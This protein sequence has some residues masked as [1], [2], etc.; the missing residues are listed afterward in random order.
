[1]KHED[2]IKDLET[3]KEFFEEQSDAYP[4][5]LEYAIE[6]L[7]K[8]PPAQPTQN[9]DSNAL[10]A[11]DCI[12]R[13]AAIEA[14]G[15]IHSLDYNAQAIKARIE[16]LPSAQP[17]IVRCKDCRRWCICHHAD[18]WFCADGERRTNE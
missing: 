3:L 9:N 1:M 17:E 15:E 12:Y 16:Q 7:K 10:K 6:A 13:Q 5:S 18:D 2:A 4:L 11:L 8:I 14:I